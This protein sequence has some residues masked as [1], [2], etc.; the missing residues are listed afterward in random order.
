MTSF[1][2]SSTIS[3]LRLRDPQAIIVPNKANLLAREGACCVQRE[4][5]QRTE[6]Q[7]I[8]PGK[9]DA[10]PL[11]P[12]IQVRTWWWCPSPSPCSLKESSSHLTLS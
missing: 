3:L 8:C 12:P 6:E 2:N 10:S 1:S 5:E 9:W 7:E 11:L 4:M